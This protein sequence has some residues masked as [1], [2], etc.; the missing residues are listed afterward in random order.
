MA[1][2][3]GR[4]ISIRSSTSKISSRNCKSGTREGFFRPGYPAL[5]PLLAAGKTGFLKELRHAAKQT[6]Q[7]ANPD[8]NETPTAIGPVDM[9]VGRPGPLVSRVN[10]AYLFPERFG[11]ILQ[12]IV[13]NRRVLLIGQNRRGK[14][15]PDRTGR[16]AYATR[17]AAGK[18]ERPDD[19]R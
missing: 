2:A 7:G 19:H 4:P 9:P 17:R 6:P 10:P 13:E 5:A 11:D 8:S 3:T 18:H 12:D 14:N 16:S 1:T 15:K